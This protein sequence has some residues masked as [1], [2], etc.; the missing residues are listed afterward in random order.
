MR[1]FVLV[2]SALALACSGAKSRKLFLFH[3]NDEHSHLLGFVP[4]GA[5]FPEPA[6]GGP[7]GIKGG[8]ARGAVVLKAQRAQAAAAGAD[9]LTVSAGDNM[10]GTLFQIAATTASADY[11]LMGPKYLAYDVTTVGNHEFDYGPNNLATSIKVAAAGDGLPTI[12]A[13]NIHFSGTTG[14]ADLAALFDETGTDTTKPIHRK[15]VVTTKS[16]L[17][18]G[19]IGIMGADAA[20]VAP[21][22]APTRFS[23]PSGSTDDTNRIAALSQIFD[24]VQPYVNSLRRDDKADVVV[25]LS[26]SGAVPGSPPTGEDISIAKNVSGVDVVVSGHSHTEVPATLI[27]NPRTGK[28]VLVQQAGRFGDNLGVISLTVPGDGTI[29]FH[30]TASHLIK[31]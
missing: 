1:R 8:G 13:T 17:K 18:V 28:Q 26:H 19:F 30:T 10:M 21:L 7:G 3:S 22:K 5:D 6:H 24:D 25:A 20:A 2:L 15:W 4:E 27:T 29:S 31:A 11:R 12:V 9:S 16:G 23:L 14:D